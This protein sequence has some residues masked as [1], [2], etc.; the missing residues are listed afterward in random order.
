MC[1]SI[2]CTISKDMD[3]NDQVAYADWLIVNRFEA[4]RRGRQIIYVRLDGWRH[5]ESLN[6]FWVTMSGLLSLIE[7]RQ[8]CRHVRSREL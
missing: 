2:P 4:F 1:Q 8:A 5:I 7:A 3:A 6:C